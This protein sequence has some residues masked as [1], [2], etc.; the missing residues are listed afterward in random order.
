MMEEMISGAIEQQKSL[1]K[2]I[3][4]NSCAIT[5]TFE[6]KGHTIAVNGMNPDLIF[7]VVQGIKDNKD[8]LREV[9]K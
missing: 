9:K 8:K 3:Q 5:I 6:L 4:M 2:D 7:K 1:V